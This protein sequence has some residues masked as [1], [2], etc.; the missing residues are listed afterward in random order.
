MVWEGAQL[1]RVVHREC[2]RLGFALKQP[3]ATTSLQGMM[4]GYACDETEEHMPA[5]IHYAHKLV[6]RQAHVRKAGVL[7]WLRPDAKSQVCVCGFLDA[8]L[9][10][11]RA[12]GREG[13]GCF[14]A[15]SELPIADQVL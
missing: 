12:G 3:L 6:E 8:C 14:K 10:C 5:P 1:N 2:Q 15:K 9:C 11:L 7:P 13:G 4:F